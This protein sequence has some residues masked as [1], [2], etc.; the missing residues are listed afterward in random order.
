MFYFKN[1]YTS[2]LTRRKMS[3][4][5]SMPDRQNALCGV[6][7][8]MFAFLSSTICIP[9]QS[10]A[11]HLVYPLSNFTSVI[12]SHSEHYSRGW[13]RPYSLSSFI[14]LCVCKWAHLGQIPYT[15]FLVPPIAS[16]AKFGGYGNSFLQDRQKRV[17]GRYVPWIFQPADFC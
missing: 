8:F 1:L 13:I 15:H 16:S 14:L 4:I 9:I 10:Q 2:P 12:E 17:G 7:L 6:H 3:K 11:S 5:C